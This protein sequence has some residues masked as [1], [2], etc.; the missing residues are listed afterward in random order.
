MSA[1]PSVRARRP[2]LRVQG[3]RGG[4]PPAG[5]DAPGTPGAEPTEHARP[6]KRAPPPTE[7]SEEGAQRSRPAGRI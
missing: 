3:V 7:R 1:V 4:R 6:A 5:G 2:E